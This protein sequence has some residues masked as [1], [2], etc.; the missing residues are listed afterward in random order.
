MFVHAVYFYLRDG[1]SPEERARFDAGV[2]SLRDIETVR[3]GWVGVPAP[4]DRPVIERGY[5]TALVLLFADQ[6]AHDAYQTHPVHD[7]FR[8]ECAGLWRDV[9]IYD[10]VDAT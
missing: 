8:A 2:R 4:T 9:R 5:H 7:R 1:L 10:S 3:Q 6:A